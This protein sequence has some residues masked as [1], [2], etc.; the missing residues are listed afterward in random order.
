MA[1]VMRG[2]KYI[3]S[4]TLHAYLKPCI[5]LSGESSTSNSFMVVNGGLDEQK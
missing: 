5:I 1:F 3:T 2:L 4:V